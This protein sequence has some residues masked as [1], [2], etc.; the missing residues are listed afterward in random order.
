MFRLTANVSCN[1]AC[2]HN[3]CWGPGDD[4][5]LRCKEISFEGRCVLECDKSRGVYQLGRECLPCDSECDGSCEGP[6]PMNCTHCKHF[7][8]DGIC[9]EQC[10]NHMYGDELT[11]LCM[12][13]NETCLYQRNDSRYGLDK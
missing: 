4:E 13:C 1:P 11:N 5:C 12:P 3:G 6:G 9:V 10:P 2:D 8:N 7:T